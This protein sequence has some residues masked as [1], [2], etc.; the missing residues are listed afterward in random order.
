MNLFHICPNRSGI[1]IPAYP[2]MDSNLT[3]CNY[4]SL[5]INLWTD[6]AF[7]PGGPAIPNQP[8][9]A[10][11]AGAVLFGTMLL[12][13]TPLPTSARH[14]DCGVEAHFFSAGGA[15]SLEILRMDRARTHQAEFLDFSSEQREF[16]A[17]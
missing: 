8:S 5:R 17:G 4:S 10:S 1:L 7:V 6:S 11:L 14:V 3:L 12:E 9:A 13:V 16:E 15:V 2:P